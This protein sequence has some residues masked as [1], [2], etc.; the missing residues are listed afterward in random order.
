LIDSS[1]VW[2]SE[3]RLDKRPS[4]Q[5]SPTKKKHQKKTNTGVLAEETLKRPRALN[6]FNAPEEKVIFLLDGAM[7]S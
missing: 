3:S 7:Q 4:D 6:V 2:N 5:W 1:P